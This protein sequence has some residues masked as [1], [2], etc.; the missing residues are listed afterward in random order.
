M[1]LYQPGDKVWVLL[2][3]TDHEWERGVVVAHSHPEGRV[4]VARA[5]LAERGLRR[6]KL[7]RHE[8]AW[9][10]T[11]RVRPVSAVDLLAELAS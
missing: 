10:G 5:E 3:G 6:G 7:D 1:T 2:S 11:W 4:A 9:V 8:G